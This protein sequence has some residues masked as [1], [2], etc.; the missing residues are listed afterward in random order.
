MEI[1]C[2]NLRIYG[3]ISLSH[4]RI[5]KTMFKPSSLNTRSKGFTLIELLVVIAIIAILASILFPVFGRARENARRSSCQ[6]NLKQIGLGF[7]QYTQDYDEKLPPP[8]TCPTPG[9]GCTNADEA[10]SFGSWSQ[11]MHPYIKS[12]QIYAC[13]SNTANTRTR[14]AAI[15]A[16]NYPAFPI[17]YGANAHYLGTTELGQAEN[18]VA[19]PS[20]KILVTE[21]DDSASTVFGAGDWDKYGGG[22]PGRG[23]ASHL[24]TMN[25]LFGDGHVKS[26][27]PLSTITPFNMW[28]AFTDTPGGGDC[29]AASW[30]SRDGA[31]N[32]NCDAPSAGAVSL[33]GRLQNTS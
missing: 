24:Q 33:L 30:E 8:G 27:K 12:V 14:D 10:R 29:T 32:P 17:S 1:T 19:S 9:G 16:L 11:R 31:Q 22:F 2:L 3:Y 20:Q 18:I 21:M 13:P 4:R 15:P 5:H 23:F 26:L 6:S 25:C 7:I 28:G